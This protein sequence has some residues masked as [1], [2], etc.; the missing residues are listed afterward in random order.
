[1][2]VFLLGRSEIKKRA[3]QMKNEAID[4]PNRSIQETREKLIIIKI[5]TGTEELIRIR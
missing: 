2:I 5:M 3:V 1:M 4:T